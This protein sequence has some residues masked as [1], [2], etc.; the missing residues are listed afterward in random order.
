M[1]KEIIRLQCKR[2]S[3]SYQLQNGKRITILFLLHLFLYKL[4]IHKSTLILFNKLCKIISKIILHWNWNKICN[5]ERYR[6]P[7][8]SKNRSEEQIR[9]FIS[10]AELKTEKYEIQYPQN[11]NTSIKNINNFRYNN[12][13]CVWSNA[14]LTT[15]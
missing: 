1:F 7:F 11:R 10:D 9:I 3:N 4:S 14:F 2:N 8:Y 12:S 13:T 6:G 15:Y 5:F